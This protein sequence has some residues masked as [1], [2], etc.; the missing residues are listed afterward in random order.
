MEIPMGPEGEKKEESP[1]SL[2]EREIWTAVAVVV[3]LVKA[4]SRDTMHHI[5]LEKRGKR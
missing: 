5:T 4:K 3:V 1:F 2:C